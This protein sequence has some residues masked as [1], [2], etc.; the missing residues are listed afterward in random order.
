MSAVS[1][2]VEQAADEPKRDGPMLGLFDGIS[3][4]DYHY[5]RGISKSGLDLI[6]KNPAEYITRKRH[7]KPPTPAMVLGTAF[8]SLVLEPDKFEQEYVMEPVNAPRRP[9]AV[10]INAKKPSPESLAAIDFWKQWDAENAGKTPIST[11]PGD[12]PFWQPSDW[13]RL[14]RM[15]DAILL[16]PIASILV[17]PGSGRAEQTCYWVDYETKKLCK[18]RPDWINDDHNLI[19]DLK[20][21]EDASYTGFGK[22]IGN[23]RYHVQDA[24]YRDGMHAI[25]QTVAGFVFL[26]VEKSPPYNVALYRLGQE[27]VRTG[28]LM[29]QSDLIKYAQC[30]AADEWPGYPEE[31]R[32]LTLSQYQLRGTVS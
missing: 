4:Q 28:R 29:Y 7:P 32:D 22:S 25:G 13:C 5:G 8:H 24:F 21:T 1:I 16:H 6:R 10:Q 30:H 17:A 3:N 19:V 20:S 31:V 11:K 23:Y 18:C 9:T 14:H 27:E 26:A 2:Q 15:R 12:D